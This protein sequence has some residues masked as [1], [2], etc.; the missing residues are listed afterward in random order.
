[1]KKRIMTLMKTVVFMCICTVIILLIT[2]FI[3]YKFNISDSKIRAGVI[4]TYFLSCFIGGFIYGGIKEKNKY[5]YGLLV[6]TAYFILV[7]I[8]TIIIKGT[9]LNINNDFMIAL[10]TCSVGGMSGGMISK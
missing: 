8:I 7:A 2:A 6:G 3:Y 4:I 9:A 5:L 10:F 1:M